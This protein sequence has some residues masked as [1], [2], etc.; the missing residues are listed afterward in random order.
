MTDGTK[1]VLFKQITTI[2]VLL[3]TTSNSFKLQNDLKVYAENRPIIR[4]VPRR[5]RPDMCE[6]GS[7]MDIRVSMV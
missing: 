3:H 5:D 7:S 1:C 2:I 4:C 6:N